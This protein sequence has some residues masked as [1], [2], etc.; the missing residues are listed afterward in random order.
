MTS[1]QPLFFDFAT[2]SKL[3]FASTEAIKSLIHVVG[4]DVCTF[5]R[6][7]Q[8]SY[9]FLELASNLW[10]EINKLINDVETSDDCDWA[11]YDKYVAAIDPLEE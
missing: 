3:H 9:R 8:V 2:E 7:T 10:A 5:R 4:A 6:N 1:V 11:A